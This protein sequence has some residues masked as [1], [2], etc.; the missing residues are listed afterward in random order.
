MRA[1]VLVVTVTAGALGVVGAS[2]GVGHDTG[3]LVSPPEAVVEQFVRK[4]AG[5]RYDV[6]EAHLD[7]RTPAWRERVRTSS[8]ALRAA[9]VYQ[10]EGRPGAATGDRASATAIVTTARAGRIV[11]SFGLVRRAGSWRIVDFD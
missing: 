8:R 4:L 9:A 1:V 11:M 5:A 2:I 7:E 10:V 6:A 3:T